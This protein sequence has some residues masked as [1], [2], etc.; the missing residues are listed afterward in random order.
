M[1]YAF[2]LLNLSLIVLFCNT[3]YAAVTDEEFE[4]LSRQVKSMEKTISRLE[5][6][7][8]KVESIE[9]E[10]ARPSSKRK[11]HD[12]N[13]LNLPSEKVYQKGFQLQLKRNLRDV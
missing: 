1:K 13:Y 3:V 7:L 12:S 2:Y 10:I 11:D 4:T 8:D 9:P 5:R 6:Y